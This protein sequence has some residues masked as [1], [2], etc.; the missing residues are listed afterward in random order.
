MHKKLFNALYVLNIVAQAFFTLLIPVAILG[1]IAWLLVEKADA[2]GWLFVPAITL[3][4]LFGIYSMV[5]FVLSA[6]NGLERLEKEQ[7]TPKDK[8]RNEQKYE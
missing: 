3:G 4:V 8:D 7:N 6:M 2:P 1:G 5:K